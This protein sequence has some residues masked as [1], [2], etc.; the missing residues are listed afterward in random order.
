MQKKYFPIFYVEI[1]EKELMEWVIHLIPCEK[2]TN[3]W[4]ISLEEARHKT[5]FCFS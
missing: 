2:E 1:K 5:M 4:S 3:L